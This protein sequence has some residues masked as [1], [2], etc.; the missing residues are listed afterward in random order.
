M[1]TADISQES[2]ESADAKDRDPLAPKLLGICGLDVVVVELAQTFRTV[3]LL[4]HKTFAR[5]LAQKVSHPEEAL[6]LREV[7][8]AP[9]G[10]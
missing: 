2:M 10:Q 4:H 3:T 5:R 9:P 6:C 8:V 1:N 7:R